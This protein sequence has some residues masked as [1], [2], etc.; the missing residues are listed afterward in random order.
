MALRA[1]DVAQLALPDECL[2]Q[3]TPRDRRVAEQLL[4]DGIATEDERH[5]LT[6]MLT[7]NAKAELQ[8]LQSLGLRFL[9][10]ALL[11]RKLVALLG[12]TARSARQH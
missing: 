1:D 4:R 12:R 7:R 3:L 10:D 5:D 9:S 2:Q 11:T 8:A 6:F